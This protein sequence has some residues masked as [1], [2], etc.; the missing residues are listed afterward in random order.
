MTQQ[1]LALHPE[2]KAVDLKNAQAFGVAAFDLIVSRQVVCHLDRPDREFERMRSLL[3]PNGMLMLVDG[4]WPRLSWS[5]E[6]LSALPSAAL[7]TAEPVT[8]LLREIGF[9][10]LRSGLFLEINKARRSTYP[11]SKDRYIVLAQRQ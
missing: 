10:V 4:F 11:N 2:L 6:Q 9:K 7:T 1:A 8:A 3:K 5:P